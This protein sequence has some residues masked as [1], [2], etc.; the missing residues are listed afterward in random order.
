MLHLEVDNTDKILYNGE[1]MAKRFLIRYWATMNFQSS[2]RPP[3]HKCTLYGNILIS[4]SH[5]FIQTFS[6][7]INVRLF[8]M[9]IY[10]K[11]NNSGTFYCMW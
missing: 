10:Q 2:L 4:L 5:S 3:W 11:Q 1:V 9:L 8:A 7:I 6:L